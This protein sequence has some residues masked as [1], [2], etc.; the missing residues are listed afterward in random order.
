MNIERKSFNTEMKALADDGIVEAIVSV[1]NNV[2]SY[3]DRVKYGFFADSLSYKMP[4]V[5]Y[6]NLKA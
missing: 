1:F 4:K 2:D 5:E 3:G 6:L